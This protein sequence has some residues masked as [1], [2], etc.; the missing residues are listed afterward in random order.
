MA[1]VLVTTVEQVPAAVA[2]PEVEQED[3]IGPGGGSNLL[4]SKIRGFGTT[5]TFD[6]PCPNSDDAHWNGKKANCA[7]F[8]ISTDTPSKLEYLE[9]MDGLRLKGLHNGI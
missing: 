9:V 8:G 5:Y 3:I 6:T 2:G 7:Y 1:A 4:C